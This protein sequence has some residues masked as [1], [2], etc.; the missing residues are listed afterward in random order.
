ML[1]KEKVLISLPNDQMG[2]AEQYLF[3][4]C[5]LL[6][7]EYIVDVVFLKRPISNFW[8]DKIIEPSVNLIYLDAS[9]EKLGFI[10]FFFWAIKNTSNYRFGLTSHVHLNSVFEIFRFLG[11]LKINKHIA[12][13][14]T[15]IFNRFNGLKLLQFKIMYLLGY[16]NIDLLI[17]QSKEMETSLRNNLKKS[18]MPKM[19]ETIPNLVNFDK[20]KNLA[21]EFS[22]PKE[23]YIISAGRLIPEKGFDI[24]INAFSE[25]QHKT[26]VQ[27]LILGEGKERGNLDNLIKSLELENRVKLIGFKSNPMPYFQGADLCVVSSRVEGFPNVLLQ[28]MTL[29]GNVISTN[30]AGGI[31]DLNGVSVCPINQ[32]KSLSQLMIKHLSDGVDNSSL[33]IEELEKR[34]P[35]SF[36]AKALELINE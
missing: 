33:F 18:W 31:T 12:R 7:S 34:S 9:T 35:S 27:L 21:K 5:I 30:C 19:V 26:K 36:F 13:E 28:M 17:S 8:N 14:S 22:P 11:F 25:I 3:E 4:M 10:N 29:N 1:R 2:G 15:F 16:Q 23:K 24:L 6:S 32:V 20:I